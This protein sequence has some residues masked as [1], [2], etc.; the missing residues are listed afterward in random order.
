MKERFA[1]VN[2]AWRYAFKNTYAHPMRSILI[3]IGFLALFTTML[4]GSTI[5]T[6]FKAYF[7]GELEDRYDEIDLKVSVD[8]SG[9]TRFFSTRDFGDNSLTDTIDD[10]IPF[11]EIDLLI[12]TNSSERFYAHLYASTLSQFKKISLSNG[13]NRTSLAEDEII[14]TKSMSKKYQLF[15]QDV[16]T[17]HSGDL[18]RNFT[19]IE[20]IEDGKLFRDN[21][22]YVDKSVSFKFFLTSLNPSLSELDSSLLVNIHNTV[23][24]ELESDISLDQAIYQIKEFPNYT[25]LNYE[26]TVDP[27]F[28]NQMVRRN[29]NVYE[30]IISI[31]MIA[32][33][34]VL[35]TTLLIYFE[36]KKKMFAIVETIGGKKWFSL[37]II[38]FEMLIYFIISLFLSVITTYFIILYGIKF[39][40]SPITYHIPFINIFIVSLI[41]LLLFA[42]STLYFFKR[43]NEHALM[44]QTKDSGREVRH[45]F[46]YSGI[47]SIV[48][49]FLY[50]ILDTNLLSSLVSLYKA[51]LQIVISI[52]FLLSCGNF[53]I[54][55]ITKIFNL[56]K[57][58]FIFFL[59]LKVLLTKKAFYQYM[60]V[61]LISTLS[62]FM[63]I[64]ANDYMGIRTSQYR[65]QYQLDFIV[66]NIIN[67][68][69]TTYQELVITS[70]VD[71]VSKVGLFQD[72]VIHDA[73]EA[74]R[75]LVSIEPESIDSF[76]NLNMTDETLDSLNQNYPVIILPTKYKELYQMKTGETIHL[77]INTSYSD[78]SFVIGGFFEKQI[79]NLAFTNLSFL[80]EFDDL[81]MNTLF[82]NAANDKEALKNVLLDEYSHKLIYII[83][84][85]AFV[86]DLAEDMVKATDYLN[87]ILVVILLCFVLSIIN[88]STL[89]IHQMKSVYAKLYILGYSHKK[90]ILLQVYESIIFFIILIVTTLFSYIMIGLKLDEFILF[91]GEYEPV[92]LTISSAITAI[93][94]S[95]ILFVMTKTYYIL[96]T[97]NIPI[98]EV[99]KSY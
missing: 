81:T 28:V 6:F 3:V 99:L 47:A 84:Y 36:D 53:L 65:S 85:D 49:L 43:F 1:K 37:L 29:I 96:Q 92:Q 9:D 97:K 89:L 30:M 68:Y 56:R 59:H 73:K 57:K 12:E 74:I 61:L 19:I 8:P 22:I 70:E 91:F 25:L 27:V 52:S 62:I 77:H 88:H 40:D 82:V 94:I 34:L 31:V 58:P 44:E 45:T 60:S 54:K 38:S 48:L 39:L 75:D 33:I 78:L 18:S 83:D 55:V 76:F 32:V 11:F 93:L 7:Y 67:D 2:F 4:L 80:D 64:L 79:G 51:P 17:L 24:I 87:I 86:T 66:T 35:Y 10:F 23:Y 5:P 46:Y 21:A 90:M 95:S 98:Q 26:K 72:V 14:I 15:N 16:I 41:S 50:F 20:I 69:E 71:A 42:L 63:L 13:L